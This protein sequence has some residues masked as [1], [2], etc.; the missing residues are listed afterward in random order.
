MIYAEEVHKVEFSE[1]AIARGISFAPVD[2]DYP[3]QGEVVKFNDFELT[4]IY[5]DQDVRV[6][7]CKNGK[8]FPKHSHPGKEWIEVLKGRITV[9]CYKVLIVG[10][11]LLLFSH[12]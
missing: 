9:Y 4:G 6:V 1:D 10:L 11:L 2:P 7:I 5:S 8:M 12:Y 3:I